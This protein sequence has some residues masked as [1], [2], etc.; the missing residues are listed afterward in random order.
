MINRKHERN[1]RKPIKP[2]K[3]TLKN[4]FNKNQIKMDSDRPQRIFRKED[5]ED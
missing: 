5:I 3:P 2:R 1:N 4:Q